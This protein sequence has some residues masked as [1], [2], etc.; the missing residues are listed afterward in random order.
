MAKKKNELSEELKN[1]SPGE[2]FEKLCDSIK[3]NN[4]DFPWKVKPKEN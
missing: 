1:L 2:I 4:P 3:R